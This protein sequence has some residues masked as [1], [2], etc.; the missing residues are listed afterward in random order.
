MKSSLERELVALFTVAF[1]H[2]L[3]LFK[4]CGAECAAGGAD[5]SVW[6][7]CVSPNLTFFVMLQPFD[8]EDRFTVEIAWS[9]DG[10]FP[11]RESGPRLCKIE[12]PKAR[13]RLPRLWFVGQTEPV[14]EVI[15]RRTFEE[16]RA[17]IK[18][19]SRGDRDEVERID[20]LTEVPLDEAM[21]RVPALVED[22][23]QKLID[24]GLP[25]FRR[26]AENRGLTWPVPDGL[27]SKGVAGEIPD[28]RQNV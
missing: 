23:V 12:G 10:K 14:W 3:P 24:Y 5:Y 21:S 8:N 22:A 4:P 18:A 20:R 13:R 9:D 27:R 1:E 17:R 2:S 26:V 15:R 25:V 7:L 19:M 6:A 16:T 28:L 11:W